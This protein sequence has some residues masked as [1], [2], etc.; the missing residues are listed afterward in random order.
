MSEITIT[1]H[2]LSSI[3][4]PRVAKVELHGEHLEGL[5]I[6]IKHS[7][8]FED[9]MHFI[10]DITE[11]CVNRE[12]GTYA[13]EA[14]E[15]SRAISILKHYASLEIPEDPNATYLLVYETD[16]LEQILPYINQTQL[17]HLTTAAQQL[18]DFEQRKI[19]ASAEARAEALF[20][21]ANEILTMNQKAFEEMYGF[22]YR[23][24][25]DREASAASTQ[26]DFGKVIPFPVLSRKDKS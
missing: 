11:N 15:I 3:K 24:L 22:D 20:D 19:A 16:L 4:T 26:Q 9:A 25:Y 8:L 17:S 10:I 5:C 21:K 18:I 1:N 23:T 6:T 7:L 2:I 12:N 13:P 14:Y